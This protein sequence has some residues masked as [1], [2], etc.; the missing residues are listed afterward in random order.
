MND[1][2]AGLRVLLVSPKP[3]PSGGIGRWTVLLLKWAA[4]R[5]DLSLRHVD[6]SPHWRAVDDMRLGRRVLGGVLQGIRDTYR[7]LVAFLVFRPHVIHLNTSARLRGPLDTAILLLA[8]LFGVRR[9]YHIRMGRMPAVM[10]SR[11]WEWQGLRWALRLADRVIV[12]DSSSERSLRGFLSA[13]RVV[14][15]P[16]AIDLN[17]STCLYGE[18][19]PP[20]VLYLGHIIPTKGMKELMEAWRELRP[21]GWSL[22]LVGLGSADYRRHLQT[23]VGPAA[24]VQFVGD[25]PPEQAWREMQEASVFVLPSY[26]E[27][28]PN[29]VLEAMAAGKA[30]V[31]T[32]VGAIPEMLDVDLPEPC[33][34]VSAPRDAQRLAAGLRRVMEDPGL[35]AK[36]GGKAR[37][38]AE[39]EYDSGRVYERLVRIWG[40]VAGRSVLDQPTA[41]TTTAA[42]S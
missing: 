36:L 37:L 15:L 11:G 22:R 8:A 29:S 25:V 40:D 13:T 28:F 30:V 19:E 16:N 27:G 41:G 26:T 4:G 12:L 31:A 10:Q 17:A 18:S 3:P 21:Q 1:P 23:I 34:I 20:R 6:I 5:P 7:C 38:K 2:A 32:R 24:D 35:R 14:R 39:R 42:P 9:V 33:G